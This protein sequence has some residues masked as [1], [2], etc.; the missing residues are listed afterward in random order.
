MSSFVLKW[1]ALISMLIDHIGFCFFPDVLLLRAVG[2]ISF[3]LFAFLL[4]KGYQYTSNLKKYFFRLLFFA[5]LSEIPFNLFLSGKIMDFSR[6]NVLFS[7]C[8][9]AAAIY[10][11]ERIS[12]YSKRAEWGLLAVTL[13][14]AT[15]QLFQTDYGAFGVILIFILFVCKDQKM[16]PFLYLLNILFFAFMAYLY[17]GTREALL[18]FCALLAYPLFLAYN[19]TSGPKFLKWFFYLFY[20]LHLLIL[21]VLAFYFPKM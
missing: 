8:F 13:I 20:P 6:Q 15:A 16:L 12:A 2:R 1:I 10:A 14:A 3:P 11:Y 4:S 21:A 5:V 17:S 19:E 18:S 7:L 9:G